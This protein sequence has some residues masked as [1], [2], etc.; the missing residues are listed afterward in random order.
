MAQRAV[1]RP[2][3]HLRLLVAQGP[4]LAGVQWAE[5]DHA[6]RSVATGVQMGVMELTTVAD[7]HAVVHD[8]LAV[9]RYDD[10]EPDTLYEFDGFA[11]RTLA[12]PA[13][14]RLATFA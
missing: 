5:R 4:G 3:R 13:G 1:P 12:R 9:R 14:A 10:L 7:D 8:G 11:F 2:T 6:P